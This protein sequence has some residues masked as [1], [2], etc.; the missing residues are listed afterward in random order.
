MSA[1]GPSGPLVS[2]F[3]SRP[4]DPKFEKKSCKSNNKKNLALSLKSL[5]FISGNFSNSRIHHY[6]LCVYSDYSR[7]P[8]VYSEKKSYQSSVIKNYFT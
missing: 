6:S 1:S 3:F 8:L 2:S 7:I 5:F 4:H